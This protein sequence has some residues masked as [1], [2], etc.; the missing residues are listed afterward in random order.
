MEEKKDYEGCSLLGNK[1]PACTSQ[2]THCVSATEHNQ[3][4][5]CKI[6]GF[7]G[8]NYEEYRLLGYKTPVLT[9]QKTD[10]VFATESIR[11]MLCK[12]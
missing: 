11:L 9:S 4:M 1:P 2:E 5:L 7:H 3:L 6:L 12:I 10:Y 8:G